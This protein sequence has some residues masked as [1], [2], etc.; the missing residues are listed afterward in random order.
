MCLLES[1]S[2]VGAQ[3]PVSVIYGHV[4]ESSEMKTLTTT[5]IYYFS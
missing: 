1:H 2:K 3:P 5:K 4:R